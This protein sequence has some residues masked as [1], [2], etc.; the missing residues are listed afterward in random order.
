M[1][2]MILVVAVIFSCAWLEK[3]CYIPDRSKIN[4]IHDDFNRIVIYHGLQV[5]NSAKYSP[6]NLPWH[7]KKDFEKM[8]TWGFN[9]VRYTFLWE[10]FEPVKG[11]YNLNYLNE[12]VKRWVWLRD[13]GID[14]VIDIHQDLYAKKFTGN[15]FPPWAIR[16][17]D[18]PFT[19]QK[20]WNLNYTEP[21]VIACYTN[22]WKN[23]T[24]KQA[25][26][27]A[28][29]YVLKAADTLD[30]VIG[31][32][33]M[34]E[35]FP[36]VLTNFEKL[37][38][39]DFYNKLQ[40]VFFKAG[41]KKRVFFE[42]AIQTSTGLPTALN[43]TPQKSAIYCPH[44][45]DPF[46]HENRPYKSENQR[47]MA[48]AIA[49]KAKEAQDFSI[50]VIF[51]EWGIPITVENYNQYITDFLDY[52]DDYCIGWSYFSYDAGSPMAILDEAGGTRVSL[53]LLSRVYPQKIAGINPVYAIKD[54][55]FN[56]SY[57]KIDTRAPTEI[58][59]PMYRLSNVLATVNG[60]PVDISGTKLIFHNDE[61]K[62]Q[63]VRI[64][65][66]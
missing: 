32:D 13:L 28:V 4:Y 1:K 3:V 33:V 48:R 53:T 62:I 6:D 35:P 11:Q 23:D 47:L 25:Y 65:W 9:L 59:I 40:D 2:L 44:Y 12:C 18:L 63:R 56:L 52:T 58:F 22:F 34:N 14:V 66:F 50:P 5:S 61:N 21:A 55:V 41:Y 19:E 20:P 30:N 27:K 37:I 45:Y 10:A 49:I 29:E 17:N 43:F 7:T 46:C 8:N 16:D 38:L 26:I 42:P 24:L 54:T 51:G 39:S 31:I 15:G 64:T 60:K 57:E 36:G